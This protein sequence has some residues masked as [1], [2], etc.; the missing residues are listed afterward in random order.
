MYIAHIAYLI[1]PPPHC[2]LKEPTI[3]SAPSRTL[4]KGSIGLYYTTRGDR[5]SKCGS[6]YSENRNY[7]NKVFS[8]HK[9]FGR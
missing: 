4:N 9:D 5:K 3:S 1:N 2:I 6:L 8:F 7:R